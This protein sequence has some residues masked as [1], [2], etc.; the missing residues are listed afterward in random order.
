M[1]RTKA[2]NINAD[3]LLGIDISSPY[4]EA[5]SEGSVSVGA[6]R[7]EGTLGI[8]PTT[9]FTAIVS[10]NARPNPRR[11]AEIILGAVARKITFLTV[12]HLVAPT[13]NE[14][15]FNSIGIELK[16]S[17][18]NDIIIGKTITAKVIDAVNKHKPVLSMPKNGAIKSLTSGTK[19]R[20]AQRPKT[21]DGTPASTSKKGRS[22]FLIFLGA[23]SAINIAL[24]KE[25]GI[26]IISDKPVTRS[27]PTI[28]GK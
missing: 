11:I 3:S 14:A 25:I 20:K 9:I 26:A 27:V 13:D 5:I 17:T 16:A 2:P 21:T 22:I 6:N 10:P 15:S 28:T 23:Y 24:N 4:L 18:H 19:K 8:P 1:K 7:D 12:S